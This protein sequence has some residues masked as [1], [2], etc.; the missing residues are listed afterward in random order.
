M[1]YIYYVL[2]S[3]MTYFPIKTLMLLRSSS[4]FADE[5][6][7]FTDGRVLLALNTF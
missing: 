7:L 3:L 6:Y 1:G 2:F 4:F 5:V